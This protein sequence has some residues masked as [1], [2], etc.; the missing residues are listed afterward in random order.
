M[1][2]SSIELMIATK[3][4]PFSRAG[5][6]FELKYDGYRALA[7]KDQLLTRNKK[8]ASTWYPEILQSLQKVR[9][10]FVI[11]GEVCL[12]DEKGIPQFEAMRGT[13]TR[14][15]GGPPVTYF[16]FDLLFLNGRDLRSLPLIERKERLRK[17]IPAQHP[18]LRFVDY[19][20]ERGEFMYQHAMQ[21]G[22]EGVVGKRADSR[23]VGG[24]SRNWLKSKPAGLHDGWKRRRQADQSTRP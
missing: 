5:W 10:S 19:L 13:T 1:I 20:E 2:L 24:Q 22:M 8:D 21:I 18:R 9:G 7:N 12:L 15:R 14:K 6:I 3:A 16:A 17:L 4:P 11:D 23:Y